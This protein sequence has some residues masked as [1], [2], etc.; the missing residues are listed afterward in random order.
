MLQISI[1]TGFEA[2]GWPEALSFCLPF[3]KTRHKRHPCK[4]S[5]CNSSLWL[6]LELRAWPTSSLGMNQ[7]QLPCSQGNYSGVN[8]GAGICSLALPSFARSL[9]VAAPAPKNQDKH[10]PRA[11]PLFSPAQQAEGGK[12]RKIHRVIDSK[13]QTALLWGLC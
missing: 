10:F 6:Q 7:Q 13:M 5:L 12:R 8:Q 3:S 11:L 9:L 1:C 4:N 2:R